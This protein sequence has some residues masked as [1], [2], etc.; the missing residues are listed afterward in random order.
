MNG[1]KP[2]SAFAQ[3]NGIRLHYLDW[4]GDGTPLVF[5][6]GMGSSAYIFS[7]FA[8]LFADRFRVIALDRRG[9]GDSD[10]ADSGYDVETLTEDLRQFLESLQIERGI[11]AGHSMGYVECC[12]FAALYPT[13]AIKV[14]FL[15]AAY[16]SSDPRQRRVWDDHPA[17]KMRPKW[18]DG[19]FSSIQEY[20]ATVQRLMP[21][22]AA[23]WGPA[24]DADVEHCVHA[25]ASGRIVDKMTE[26]SSQAL[27]DMMQGYKPEFAGISVPVLSFFALRDGRDYI[28]SEWM[29][30]EQQREVIDYSTNV[31]QAYTRAWAEEFQ[32]LVPQAR[33]VLIPN[34]HHYCFIKQQALVS[35]EMRR[36]LVES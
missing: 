36:F 7:E 2:H 20:S 21:S 32:R 22:L 15:D 10:Y 3:V 4:G 14:I 19:G 12:H 29:T 24:L 5:L 1:A 16:D 13:R 8:P 28:S 18:P 17:L 31:I 26:S 34:G 9:I 30:G 27:T 23:I 11:L 25:D 33:V 35:E 6:P